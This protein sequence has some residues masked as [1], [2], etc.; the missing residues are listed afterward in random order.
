MPASCVLLDRGDDGSRVG[1]IEA[2][3]L[4]AAVDHFLD[5]RHLR[6]RVARGR[7]LGHDNLESVRLR[8]RL[9]G[10]AE[11][12][13]EQIRQLLLDDPDGVPLFRGLAL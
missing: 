7:R 13:K 9:G 1:R 8:L 4:D 2:D 11:R 6:C 5:S 12:A 10:V 3:A